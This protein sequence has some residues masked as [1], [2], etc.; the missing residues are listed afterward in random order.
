MLRLE[1]TSGS[2]VR[3][4]PTIIVICV[5]S[6][7]GIRCPNG[8]VHHGGWSHFIAPC[9]A[10]CVVDGIPGCEIG[11]DVL[12]RPSHGLVLLCMS[13][14]FRAHVLLHCLFPFSHAFSYANSR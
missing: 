8:A 1:G 10:V 7:G 12:Y 5:Q 2:K 4:I 14:D 6:I 13:F 3:H 9:S 11:V